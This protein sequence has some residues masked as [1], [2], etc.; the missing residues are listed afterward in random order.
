MCIVFIPASVREEGR[1]G[2]MRSQRPGGCGWA[3]H[4]SG[5]L[6]DGA[7]MQMC[8]S[9]PC[10]RKSVDHLICSMFFSLQMKVKVPLSVMNKLLKMSYMETQTHT[11][12]RTRTHTAFR[13]SEHSMCTLI[14]ING[15]M[16]RK[17]LTART[18]RYSHTRSSTLTHMP[19]WCWCAARVIFALAR[20]GSFRFLF[21]GVV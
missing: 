1:R 7:C 9:H 10:V 11:H 19:T 15:R 8:L 6:C 14:R 3:R 4:T 18:A 5:Q 20:S 16:T 12:T 21:L 17:H 2:Q 13:S